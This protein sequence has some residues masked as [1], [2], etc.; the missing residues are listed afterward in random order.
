MPPKKRRGPVGRFN[1]AV[2]RA[3][4]QRLG[5]RR[6]EAQKIAEILTPSVIPKIRSAIRAVFRREKKAG[7]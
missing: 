5:F 4:L 7:R 2:R 3:T 1:L 6:Q